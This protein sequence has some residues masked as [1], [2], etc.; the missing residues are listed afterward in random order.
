MQ[1]SSASVASRTGG[2]TGSLPASSEQD[3][4]LLV[5][6]LED[7]ADKMR[8]PSRLKPE[9]DFIRY[10]LDSAAIVATTDVQG[11]I[12]Y[13]NSKFCE[14]SGYAE[15]ELLGSNHRMLKSG[16]HDVGFFRAMY[17]H[18]ARGE[19][20]HGEICNRRKDGSLYWVFT[21]IVPHVSARGKID[22]YTSIRFDITGRKLLEQ[23]LRASK[24]ELKR[25]ANVDPQTELANRRRF[26]EY[27]GGLVKECEGSGGA[28]HLAL[29]DV[30]MFKE[31]NDSSGH[32]AGDE[33]LNAIAR[34]LRELADERMF[35][36][37]VGGDEFGLVF[38]GDDVAAADAFFERALEA[39]RR[40]IA[41][42]GTARRCSAS[43]G[44]A[45]FPQ[46]GRGADEIFKAA[47]LALYHAKAL[48]RDRVEFFQPRLGEVAEK[49]SELLAEIE[50][51]LRGQE[52]EFH[53]QPI[54]R[55]KPDADVALEA[56]MRWR[57]PQ[58][59][60][61]TPAAFR[62][63]FSDHQVRAALGMYMLERVFRDTAR[64]HAAN[65]PIGRVA[66]N[67]TNSDFRSDVFLD[68]FFEL[69]A[70]TGL[71]PTRFCVEVTEGM[72]LGLSQK[73][74]KQGLQRLHDAGVEIALDDFGTG[75]ASLTHLR[76]LPI[77]R[78][79]IDRSFIANMVASR[80]DQA[81]VRGVVEIAHSLG[82]IVTA[83]GVETIEQA[84]LLAGMGC[85]MLQGWYFGK[86]CAASM[87]ADALKAMPPVPQAGETAPRA[88]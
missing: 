45:S 76:Q 79:K 19:V 18:I 52:F 30:D 65:L 82:A 15:E 59:G 60:L 13:V 5:R 21:T 56:L 17:R 29:L 40:P 72:F 47:D 80:E 46:H 26:Q 49:K 87:L 23:E 3:I 69:C 10:A 28:F 8:S 31:V 53:Y 61:L 32:P 70:Q 62:E 68:R 34:R 51:G 2:T 6:A 4:T 81:I 1:N 75:F 33:L 83:E 66:I 57:H 78:L 67:L 44:V 39:I 85:D 84:E 86:A 27:V 7:V 38:T 25:L 43:L 36:S 63:G 16:E 12:N 41:I 48:G 22:S 9:D 35:I 64:F 54:V 77:D 55:L 37:R 58:R 71:A 73:R 20:W 50:N 42:A 24:D 74:V 14:I 88:V 11:T